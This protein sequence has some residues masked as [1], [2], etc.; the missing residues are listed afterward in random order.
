MN[1]DPFKAISV[2]LTIEPEFNARADMSQLLKWTAKRVPWIHIMSMAAECS[3]NYSPLG[4][5]SSNVFELYG[6]STST[7]LYD[8]TSKFPLPVVTGI[9][10]GALGNL[11][12]TR[13]AT[14]KLKA[15]TDEQ[16]IELQKCY[17]VPGMDVRCQFGW[18]E[19]CTGKPPPG[20]YT[21]ADVSRQKAVCEIASLAQK[22]PS[23]DGFQGIVAGFSY[24]L[25]TDNSWECSVEVN[26]AAEAFADG[27]IED[28]ECGCARAVTQTD[29]EGN[30]KDIVAKYGRL[31][32]MLYDIF[33]NSAIKSQYFGKL[34]KGTPKGLHA[35]LGIHDE[36]YKGMAR[37]QDGKDD[38]GWLEGTWIN[39]YDTTE[40][41]I[42]WGTL[43]AAINKYTIPNTEGKPYGQID[44]SGISLPKP[45]NLMSSDPRVCSIPG[46]Q[47]LTQSKGGVGSDVDHESGISLCSIRLNVIFL[48]MELK[49]T[50]DGDKKMSTFIRAVIDKV[51]DVCGNPWNIEVVCTG[52]TQL[53][54][55]SAGG[56][57]GGG[58]ISIIDHKSF[59]PGN[60]GIFELKAKVESSALRNI[61]LEMKMTGAMKTQALYA[62]GTQQGGTSSKNDGDA[63]GCKGLSFQPFYVGSG[64]NKAMPEAEPNK[65]NT[66]VCDC[67]EVDTPDKK[68]PP[69]K[70][71]LIEQCKDEINDSTCQ[72]L[73]AEIIREMVGEAKPPHCAGVM[74]PFDF[75]FECDGIGGF[76]FSQLISCDRIPPA[77][78]GKMVWQI[79][80]VDHSITANDWTTKIGTVCRLKA[81]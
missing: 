75:S 45:N 47:S 63:T 81:L 21:A 8:T 26:S 53:S 37:T 41:Y 74:L 65:K 58:T 46:Q 13:K 31:Y 79:T 54:C 48:M 52:D 70:S 50:F 68:S 36:F 23:Y 69:T 34:S 17:F 16:L 5:G 73:R 25:Q 32:T 76:R 22:S 18:N 10:I 12:T 19:S 28:L 3:S 57:D 7:A 14:I 49:K 60:T 78:R 30:E 80:K 29:A 24:N 38:S 1:R 27:S 6:S 77:I 33:K 61:S 66:P 44:S 9:D 20:I 51:N 62:G 15:Y 64:K 59:A 42:T 4:K 35:Y 55:D 39:D 72:A 40:S 2:P 56:T 71:E 67:D 43:E 11:G